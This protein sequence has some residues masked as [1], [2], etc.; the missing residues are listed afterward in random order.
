M[1]A[2]LG[3]GDGRDVQGA[4]GMPTK[5]QGHPVTAFPSPDFHRT[6][7]LLASPTYL[8]SHSANV[9]IYLLD[10]PSGPDMTLALGGGG[11]VT[12]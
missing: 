10:V 3:W 9:S 7:R 8:L 2:G 11:I 6:Q 1:I 5:S 12:Q 4:L